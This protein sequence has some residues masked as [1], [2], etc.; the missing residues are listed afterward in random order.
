MIFASRHTQFFGRF[1]MIQAAVLQP[2]GQVTN[3][4]SPE[5]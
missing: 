4:V 3:Q 2:Q 1:C 5:L